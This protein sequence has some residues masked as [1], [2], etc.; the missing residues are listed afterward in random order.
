M[1]DFYYCIR[2]KEINNNYEILWKKYV[3]YR[4]DFERN[5]FK[6]LI[7]EEKNLNVRI[8][9]LAGDKENIEKQENDLN[10]NIL[11]IRSIDQKKQKIYSPLKEIIEKNKIEIVN[12]KNEV[13]SNIIDYKKD[14]K[15]FEKK[16]K[17]A[18]FFLSLFK[19]EIL[20]IYMNI[21][22][23]R[24][25][26][27]S[28]EIKFDEDK[29]KHIPILLDYLDEKIFEYQIIETNRIKKIS[30]IL[31][32]IEKAFNQYLLLRGPKIALEKFNSFFE[33]KSPNG[34]KLK[35]DRN[36]KYFM[37]Y[38]EE[39]LYYLINT[40][41]FCTLFKL[42][43]NAGFIKYS[44]SEKYLSFHLENANY[45]KFNLIKYI[46]PNNPFEIVKSTKK[47][48]KVVKELNLINKNY[49]F[50]IM[51]SEL[52]LMPVD[53]NFKKRYYH[54]GDIY[55]LKDDFIKNNIAKYKLEFYGKEIVINNKIYASTEIVFFEILDIFSMILLKNKEN[56]QEIIW[57]KIINN[58][59][60]NINNSNIKYI[61]I[62]ELV[63]GFN[64]SIKNKNITAS[65]YEKYRKN[66]MTIKSDEIQRSLLKILDENYEKNML[67]LR[68]GKS[69]NFISISD[70]LPKFV[71]G[72]VSNCIMEAEYFIRKNLLTKILTKIPTNKRFHPKA[73]VGGSIPNSEKSSA[74]FLL[75]ADNLNLSQDVK[76]FAGKGVQ[77]V[78][79]NND[80]SDVTSIRSAT[81]FLAA[82]NTKTSNSSIDSILDKTIKQIKND[83]DIYIK[84]NDKYL[85]SYEKNMVLLMMKKE[86]M[87]RN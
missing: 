42:R 76:N 71:P 37:D 7:D 54:D 40:E 19:S 63:E 70:H 73:L 8:D 6:K 57:K 49:P 74:K 53:L 24:R 28:L 50:L 36:L 47:I 38:H 41:L 67:N 80:I 68:F 11:N 15:T 72:T 58:M 51:D 3:N 65:E 14:Q 52:N 43:G 32:A 16:K 30:S 84:E 21:E 69:H 48:C 81:G 39:Y 5:Y 29:Y 85:K 64:N 27:K 17:L 31:N 56:T 86:I 87:Q 34:F 61:T 35:K 78:N 13:D 12:N 20:F 46:D 82:M 62:K 45:E 18:D 4:I 75:N 26:T 60:G 77:N 25:V 55:S 59:N 10:R 66:I 22:F 9:F 23:L 79:L 1:F 44:E 83:C 2:N 33:E